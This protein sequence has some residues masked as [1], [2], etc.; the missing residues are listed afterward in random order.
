MISKTCW[1]SLLTFLGVMPYLSAISLTAAVR[2]SGSETVADVSFVQKQLDHMESE[3]G[4]D[5]VIYEDMTARTLDVKVYFWTKF[6]GGVSF[7]PPGLYKSRN[8]LIL[9][10]K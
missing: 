10:F 7:M 5:D 8:F 2:I 3:P 1:I 4:K 6:P 9:S